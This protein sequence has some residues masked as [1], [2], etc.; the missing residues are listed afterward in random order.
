VEKSRTTDVAVVGGGIIGLA[1][2]LALIREGASVR[3]LEAEPTVAVHQSGRNSGVLHSGLYY[4]PGS[5]KARLCA[6]GRQAMVAYCEAHEIPYRISGKLVV[7]VGEEDLSRL[8]ELERRGRANGLTGIE[9]IGPEE[10]RRHE[11]AASGIAG[12][13]V[14]ETGV[15]DFAAVTRALGDEIVAHGGQ[16][17]TG[18]RVIGVAASSGAVRLRTTSHSID[19]GLLVNCAGLQSDRIARM[20]GAELDVCILPIRGEYCELLPEAGA[21]VNGLIYPVPDPALPFLGVHLTRSLEDRV[22][23]GPNAVLAL[24]REGYTRGAFSMRDVFATLAWPGT[25][26]MS[27]QIW[28][29][30]AGEMLRAMSRRRFA[31]QAARLVPAL[32]PEHFRRAGSGVRAQAVDRKGQLVDD[33]RFAQSERALHVLNAPSPGA[34]ASLAIGEEIARRALQA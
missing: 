7:A 32:R 5:L 8:Q 25:W 13:W 2:A 10:I 29:T 22:T 11:P 26:R 27:S 18:H 3:V 16:V 28:R 15:V 17:L 19:A 24:K 33:F 21:W 9:R 4:R 31:R 20:A 1:T 23:A 12:L 6:A 30:A 34:T 14:P